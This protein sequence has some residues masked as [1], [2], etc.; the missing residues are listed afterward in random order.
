MDEA[1]LRVRGL[2][3]HSGGARALSDVDL[4]VHAGE[5]H[6]LVGANGAGKSTLIRCLAGVVQP[7]EGEIS[8]DGV[9]TAINSPRDAEH[10]GL[11]FIHLELNLVPHFSSLENILLGAPKVKRGGLIDWKRSSRPAYEAAERIGVR[12][13][14]NRRVDELSV[15]EQWL[16]MISKALVRRA[17]MIAMDEPTASLSDAESRRLFTVVRDLAAGGVAI[18]YVSHRLDEV[19][20]LSDRITVFRD[21]RVTHQ[22][23]RGDLDKRGLLRAIV[24]REVAAATAV[25]AAEPPVTGGAGGEV[26][27]AARNVSRGHVVRD[28]SFEVR[29]GEV[30]GLG[31]LGGAGRTELA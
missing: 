17:A 15:A 20:D 19:L 25:R 23:V 26:V 14:L 13:S 31:G 3:K 4:D 6:G 1:W 10:A 22:A 21:G 29:A 16:V 2:S 8:F 30:L 24:G 27:F 18:L 5:V 28:V 9:P 11:A 12:F 7:D